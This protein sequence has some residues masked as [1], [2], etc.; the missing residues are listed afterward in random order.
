MKRSAIN[1]RPLLLVPKTQNPKALS[2]F[3]TSLLKLS[4]LGLLKKEPQAAALVNRLITLRSPGT[5]YW[6]W[7]YSFPWQTRTVLVQRGA[8]N[9]V[10]T[11]FVAN[12]F[13]DAYEQL[14]DSSYLEMAASACEYLVKELFYTEPDG[15]ASF[16]Y[17][18]P[19][20]QTKVH[21]ANLLA[22]AVLSRVYHHNG[23]A[24]LLDPALQAARYSASKQADDGSWP[25]GELPNQDWIDNFHT[26]YN[27][28]ALRTI[29][30]YSGTTEFESHLRRGFEFYRKH[31]L[32]EDGAV[33]YFHN[34]TYPI[35][36]H[37]IAQSIL[38]LLEFQDLYPSN[39]N[40][41]RS[42]YDWTM[43]HMWD[44]AGFFYYR[45]L[46]TIKIRTSYMRWSQA[47]MLLTLATLA[48]QNGRE[49]APNSEPQSLAQALA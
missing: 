19:G 21:N 48:E 23:D 10:C 14:G 36:I 41:V 18:L 9:L 35:D 42:T 13:L 37:C 39:I 31:F 6:C 2:L 15:V 40:L 12:S 46:R 28:N 1:L 5:P 30:R 24:R 49:I 44:K 20:L 4:R 17:P 11:V 22:A 33:R 25:Y 26:G 8:P 29:Q 47:W 16:S 3:L 43:R 27:L 7:G 32:R 34:S 45:V 38:T